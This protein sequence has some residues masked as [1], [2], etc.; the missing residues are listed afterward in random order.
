MMRKYTIF[1]ARTATSDCAKFILAGFDTGEPGKHSA[2]S[3]QHSVLHLDLL[4]TAFELMVHSK[5]PPG[6][7]SWLNADS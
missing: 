1:P 6:S 3:S 2:I 7:F 4:Q 5:S